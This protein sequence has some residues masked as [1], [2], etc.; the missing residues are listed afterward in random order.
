MRAF[1]GVDGEGCNHADGRQR[2]VLLRA[3]DQELWDPSLQ[4]LT[5]FDCLDF[6]ATLA[7]GPIYVG[8]SFGYDVSQILS[9]MWAT[10]RTESR[11]TQDIV[12]SMTQWLQP[13]RTRA[14]EDPE[15]A[16]E[17]P[18][19]T[20]LHGKYRYRLSWMAGK[21]F[22][23]WR[24]ARGSKFGDWPER[25]TIHDVFGFFSSSFT[26][27][28]TTWKVATPQGVEEMQATKDIRSDFSPERWAASGDVLRAYCATECVWLARLMAAFRRDCIEAKVVPIAWEGAGNLASAMLGSK[29]TFRNDQI[30]PK[31][32]EVCQ[33]ARA[34]Y[35]GGHFEVSRRGL[36]SGPVHEYDINSAYPDAML[37]LPC[38][39]HTE[40]FDEPTPEATLAFAEVTWTEYDDR[41]TGWGPFPFRRK[42]GT[43]CN[44]LFGSG[45]YPGALIRVA[46]RHGIECAI[47]KGWWMRTMCD[48]KPFAWVPDVYKQR[49][50]LGASTRGYP[51][52]LGLNSCYGKFCQSVGQPVYANP[53]YA[54]MITADCRARVDDIAMS[55]PTNTV[56]IA[57]DGVYLSE[58]TQPD[59][60]TTEEKVLGE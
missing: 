19:F 4:G 53:I 21:N 28:C 8:Y 43:I 39:V 55:H 12:D 15:R 34:S 45:W 57:T 36:V 1:I 46:Q 27:A 58:G 18:S 16:N 25:T 32:L 31:L 13:D 47:S 41:E 20:I 14:L 38:L 52:K 5:G 17:L 35:Y 9:S 51:L 49:L 50:A 37:R 11:I 22:S 26:K 29:R 30:T 48:C 54:A 59:L 2:Y 3:G 60:P 6:I 24:Q 10:L 40:W 23:V 33:D 44:P 56:M 7:P 42:G